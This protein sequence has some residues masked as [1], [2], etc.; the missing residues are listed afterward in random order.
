M[1][2]QEYIQDLCSD[3]LSK[4]EEY[5]ENSDWFNAEALLKQILK[6]DEEN[7]NAKKKLANVLT[8]QNKNE[9][10]IT[11]YESLLSSLPR[12]YILWNDVALAYSQIGDYDTAKNLLTE[13]IE[14]KPNLPLAYNNLAFQYIECEQVEKAE[15]TYQQALKIIPE[16]AELWYQYG[17]F[18]TDQAEHEKAVK[19]YLTALKYQPS[20]ATAHYN[21]SL[22]YLTL[23]QYAKGFSEYEYRWQ[24]NKSFREARDK[25]VSPGKKYW[26]GE[27]LKDKKILVFNEQGVGDAFQFCR[28]LPKL[29]ELGAKRVSFEVP[30]DLINLF[31]CL[32][33]VNLI[34]YGTATDDDYDYY[35][36]ICSLPHLLLITEK[37]LTF[38]PYL[39]PTGNI[40]PEHFEKYADQ[41][42]IGI[43]WAGNPAHRKDHLRSFSLNYFRPI[44][45]LDKVKLFSLQKDVRPRFWPKAGTIDLTEDCDD[46]S[47][48]DMRDVMLDWNYTAA[49]IEKMDL[50]ITADSAV[51][52]LAGA[53]NKTCW[54]LVPFVSDWRWALTKW[55]PSLR[56][57]HQS[58]KNDWLSV[59]EIVTNEL[60]TLNYTGKIFLN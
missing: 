50:I 34:Q 24:C 30:A 49:I 3:S 40:P 10:A 25:F 20:M 43:V 32:K 19:A 45:N 23:G 18:L 26:Q 22:A 37:S 33:E 14:L 1:F 16:S 47:V 2:T 31:S 9:E 39:K 11:L 59:F 4:A 38:C 54:I 53:M 42:K 21:L 28:F 60:I 44:H 35:V 7:I 12:E 46:L 41:I 51:A 48:V 57:F 15:K 52:H 29:K 5:I 56:I 17:A 13:C 8:A 6:V 36:S 55:Y 27:S 58:K